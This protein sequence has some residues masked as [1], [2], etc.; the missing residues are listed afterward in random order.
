MKVV[1]NFGALS[2]TLGNIVASTN[3][4]GQYFRAKGTT[5]NPS[6]ARQLAVRAALSTNAAAWQALTDAQRESWAEYALNHPYTNTLGQERFH[7]AQQVYTGINSRLRDAGIA[8]LTTAPAAA[9]PAALASVSGAV[10]G[11][12]LTMTLTFTTTPLAAGTRL[13]IRYTGPASAGKDPNV[14]Q[15]RVLGYSAAAA[16][17]GITIPLR[18]VFATGQATNLYVYVMD[19][20]GQISPPLKARMVAT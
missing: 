6:T 16:A 11:G 10:V 1:S 7:T 9:V 8:V 18:S 17:T 20:F 5:T 4:G 15:A 2:G 14:N 13:Q 12:A 19:A 3:L